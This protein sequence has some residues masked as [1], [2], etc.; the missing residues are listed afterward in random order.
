M[1]KE[2]SVYRLPLGASAG[3]VAVCEDTGRIAVA[4]GRG[5]VSLWEAPP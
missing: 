2:L 1:S 3:A 4:S 5:Y